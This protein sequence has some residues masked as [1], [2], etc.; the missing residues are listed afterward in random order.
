[1]REIIRK[2]GGIVQGCMPNT[3]DYRPVISLTAHLQEWPEIERGAWQRFSLVAGDFYWAFFRGFEELKAG[4]V[5]VSQLAQEEIT[6]LGLYLEE[7]AGNNLAE[8]KMV[9]QQLLEQMAKTAAINLFLR[10]QCVQNSQYLQEAY[11]TMYEINK[12]QEEAGIKLGDKGRADLL[13]VTDFLRNELQHIEKGKS[14]TEDMK[15]LTEGMLDKVNF[16]NYL[17]QVGIYPAGHIPELKLPPQIEDFLSECHSLESSD[18]KAYQVVTG[19]LSLLK[20]HMTRTAAEVKVEHEGKLIEEIIKEG[21]EKL[22]AYPLPPFEELLLKATA[23]EV[24]TSQLPAAAAAAVSLVTETKAEKT[25]ILI[26]PSCDSPTEPELSDETTFSSDTSIQS[27][28][29]EWVGT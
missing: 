19:L 7:P 20:E 18:L 26:Q 27:A 14:Y 17:A 9:F 6:K 23:A 22:L 4:K 11:K 28:D 25:P 1:M 13:K 12:E 3:T 15:L 5:K 21:T 10:K 2:I 29:E 16:A 24:N 8:A